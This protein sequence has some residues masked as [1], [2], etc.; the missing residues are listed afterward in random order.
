MSTNTYALTNED[1]Q[2]AFKAVQLYAKLVSCENTFKDIN[3]ITYQVDSPNSSDKTFYVLWQGNMHCSIMS[4]GLPS[5]V[6]EVSTKGGNGNYIILNDFAFGQELGINYYFIDSIKKVGRNFEVIARD[7][8]NPINE[9][10][11]YPSNRFKYTLV[12]N[13]DGYGWKL[14]S[15]EFLGKV[16]Y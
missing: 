2:K 5:Y 15:K 7:F 10:Q 1:K 8:A 3:Q 11:Y 9:N 12:Q 6:T 13:E 4:G 14:S 16:K